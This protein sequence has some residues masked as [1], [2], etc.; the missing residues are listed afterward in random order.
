[1]LLFVGRK[2]RKE[3]HQKQEKSRHHHHQVTTL[4]TKR[5]KE[6]NNLF[7]PYIFLVENDLSK[8]VV[9]VNILA[10]KKGTG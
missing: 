1:M 10:V 6:K 2:K 4:E 9:A 8:L 5:E 7:E 3:R